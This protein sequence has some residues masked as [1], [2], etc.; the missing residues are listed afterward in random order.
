M[1]M[2]AETIKARMDKLYNSDWVNFNLF[3]PELLMVSGMNSKT[4]KEGRVEWKESAGGG[5]G[6]DLLNIIDDMAKNL[7]AGIDC[8]FSNYSTILT[9]NEFNTLQNMIK[10]GLQQFMS[11]NGYTLVTKR[12]TKESLEVVLQDE[13]PVFREELKNLGI[14]PPNNYLDLLMMTPQGTL[15]IVDIKSHQG[16]TLGPE[17]IA[18]Y[19]NQLNLYAKLLNDAIHRYNERNQTDIKGVTAIHLFEVPV[20]TRSGMN[21]NNIFNIET[22]T[23]EYGEE[24][25]TFTRKTD[26]KID[27]ISA[28]DAAHLTTYAIFSEEKLNFIMEQRR[29]QIIDYYKNEQQKEENEADK[30][31]QLSTYL[32]SPTVLENFETQDII[33]I[34]TNRIDDTNRFEMQILTN[35]GDLITTYE[36]EGIKG[37]EEII[38]EYKKQQY[39][40][41]PIIEVE[42]TTVQPDDIIIETQGEH[43]RVI[44]HKKPNNPNKPEEQKKPNQSGSFRRRPRPSD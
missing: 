19:V 17:F 5:G 15:A 6:L 7:A 31:A 26:T 43:C 37:I 36:V 9:P 21:Y 13:D 10:T 39:A 29:K 8:D 28:D 38:K 44:R 33:V 16:D 20:A 3:V 23:T 41:L 18:S 22:S 35:Q 25:K 24:V 32:D 11:M 12:G 1:A 30:E 40:E 4:D 42:Q 27:L 34:K 14:N 2:T